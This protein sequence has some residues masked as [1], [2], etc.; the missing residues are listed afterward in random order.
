M[1][2]WIAA[3]DETGGWDIVDGSF[4]TDFTGLAWVLG[5]VSVWERALQMTLGGSTALE[6][7]SRPFETRLPDGVQLQKNSTKYHL[8]DIWG[9]CRKNSLNIDIALDV[10]QE[11]PV[12]ELLRGDAEW[13]LRQSGLGVL[14]MGGSG[15]DGKAA[16]LGFSGDGLRERA[17]AFAGLMTVALPFLPGDA[18]LNLLAE[19]RTEQAIAD[20]AKYNLFSENV[21]DTRLFEPYRNFIGHLMEDLARASERCQPAVANGAPISQFAC[22]G[23]K[24]RDGLVSLIE[25]LRGFPFLRAHAAEAVKAMNGVA[26]LAAALMPRPDSNECRIVVPEDFSANLWA[27]NFRELRHAIHG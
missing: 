8:M 17:R 11:D 15:A 9:Y 24:G 3:G 14:A 18:S 22:K 23:S 16:G 5:P 10:P 26:D 4:R 7:F 12:L 19:G 20:A 27:G 25:S 13:L 2:I 6:L 21:S 1:E